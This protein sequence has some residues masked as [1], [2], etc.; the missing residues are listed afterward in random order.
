MKVPLDLETEHQSYSRT[1]SYVGLHIESLIT[2]TYEHHR[3]T[4]NR[5]P[6]NLHLSLLTHVTDAN[7]HLRS[8]LITLH[9]FG[10]K[11]NLVDAWVLR[12][13]RFKV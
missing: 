6:K 5:P 4:Q 9:K 13:P 10:Y 12:F 2:N 1:V 8:H 3:S 7:S 11:S